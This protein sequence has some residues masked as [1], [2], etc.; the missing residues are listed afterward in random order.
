MGGWWCREGSKERPVLGE[1]CWEPRSEKLAGVTLLGGQCWARLM[2]S[3]GRQQFK[4]K[5]ASAQRPHVFVFLCFNAS[6]FQSGLGA[7]DHYQV[8]Q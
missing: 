2:A 8:P 7:P 5:L 4:G 6:Y 1:Q 3:L